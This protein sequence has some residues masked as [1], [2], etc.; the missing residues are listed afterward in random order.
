[1]AILENPSPDDFNILLGSGKHVVADF[2]AEW[3]GPCR[4]ITPI[5]NNLASK[6]YHEVQFVKINVDR[7]PSLAQQYNIMSIPTV[8]FFR[9]NTVFAKQI[10]LATPGHFEDLITQFLN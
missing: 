5:I 3:C 4:R 6:Y 9:N 1:M 8:I 7:S 10:G 2:W